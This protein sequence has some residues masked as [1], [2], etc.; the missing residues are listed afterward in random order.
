RAEEMG[1]LYENTRSLS[2]T[3]DLPMLLPA[4]VE[5]ATILL[6]VPHGTIFLHDRVRG[7]LEMVAN[8]RGMNGAL[9]RMAIGHGSVG[10]AALTRQTLLD[11]DYT[12]SEQ[13]VETKQHP[14]F[15]AVL[16]APMLYGGEL[17][18]VLSL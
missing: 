13:R 12:H 4:L 8:T 18:G 9:T 11:N 1:A 7:D 2:A 5:R 17:I 15:V 10:R 6:N 14:E 3:L 16:S